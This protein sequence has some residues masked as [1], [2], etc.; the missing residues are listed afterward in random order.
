M[1][2]LAASTTFVQNVNTRVVQGNFLKPETVLEA[3]ARSQP[4]QDGV[5]EITGRDV[6]GRLLVKNNSVITDAVLDVS[7]ETGTGAVCKL[8]LLPHGTFSFRQAAPADRL[9]FEQDLGLSFNDVRRFLSGPSSI[10]LAFPSTQTLETSQKILIEPEAPSTSFQWESTSFYRSCRSKT[11]T[12]AGVEANSEDYRDCKKLIDAVGRKRSQ[13][14]E[15][16]VKIKQTQTDLEALKNPGELPKRQEKREPLNITP[17]VIGI[18]VVMMLIGFASL[19]EYVVRQANEGTTF[20][21]VEE[22]S[23]VPASASKTEKTSKGAAPY[24]LP[25]GHTQNNAPPAVPS[26]GV[27]DS[28]A[29]PNAVDPAASDTAS[30]NMPAET[31]VPPVAVHT[32]RP[33]AD[34][35]LIR[36][37]DSVRKDPS[38]ATARKQLAHAYLVNR[39]VANS[40][41]QFH[42][43]MR[44]RQVQASEITGYADSLYVFGGKD[45]AMRFL[46]DILRRDPSQSTIR[47]KMADLR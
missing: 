19:V 26:D 34:P 20:T 13:T 11:L 35:E 42:A 44:L 24:A 23:S 30:D 5:I 18:A 28:T 33:S 41:E 47:A 7:G 27:A 46:G 12:H 43:M 22:T 9:W 1:N 6:R 31:Y 39:D 8:L 29:D 10:G 36:C 45:A 38:S 25:S 15:T 17:I 16:L 2:S 37:L 4:V 14:L 3:V 21:P 40:I 32:P